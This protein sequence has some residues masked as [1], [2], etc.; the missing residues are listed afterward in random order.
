MCNLIHSYSF[1]R[2]VNIIKQSVQNLGTFTVQTKVEPLTTY[3]ITK[4]Q[5]NRT[6][7]MVFAMAYGCYIVSENWVIDRI[8]IYNTFEMK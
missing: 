3:L 8:P 2:E 7:N 5:P 1:N 4:S 6:L